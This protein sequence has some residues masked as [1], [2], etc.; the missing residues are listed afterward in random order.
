MKFPY[1]LNDFGKLIMQGHFY[2]DRQQGSERLPQG[3]GRCG[4]ES[5][6]NNQIA[7]GIALQSE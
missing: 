3:C 2:Q 7:A 5:A 1:A 6:A 4:A